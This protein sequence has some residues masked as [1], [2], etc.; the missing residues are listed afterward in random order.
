MEIESH[1]LLLYVAVAFVTGVAISRLIN[2]YLES[3]PEI[4]TRSTLKRYGLPVDDKRYSHIFNQD[5]EK[6]IAAAKELLG[7]LQPRMKEDNKKIQGAMDRM[8]DV[9]LDMNVE[10]ERIR[11]MET[12]G[13][14]R[15]FMKT[16]LTPF[17]A[18]LRMEGE[19]LGAALSSKT[20]ISNQILF[21]E[22]VEQ[23]HERKIVFEIL[24]GTP[25][26]NVKEEMLVDQAITAFRESLDLDPI[27]A[28]AAH[29]MWIETKR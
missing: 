10:Q 3:S 15:A 20:K 4:M 9:Q 12:I 6:R 16:H 18:D 26:K 29:K 17:L 27:E 11:E 24:A 14:E 25:F 8:N 7:E 22:Q 28:K 2:S 1:M 21:I 5:K 13:E 19:R 23:G